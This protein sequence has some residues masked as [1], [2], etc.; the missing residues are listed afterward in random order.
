MPGPP[1]YRQRIYAKYASVIQHNQGSFGKV[2]RR[3]WGKAYDYYL[4]GWL[5]KPKDC[6][7][8]DLGC[9]DGRLLFFFKER[10]Y[11]RLYGVDLSPEQVSLAQQVVPHIHQGDI[12]DY[13]QAHKNSFELITGLDVIEH[14]NKDE[15]LN[16]LDLCFAALRSGGR[17]VLQTPNAESPWGVSHRY[18][19]FTH[20]T[21]FNPNALLC[22]LKICGF[23]QLEARE[24]G[25]VPWRYSFNSTIRYIIWQNIRLALMLWNI[26]EMGRPGS[27]VFTRMFLACAG[28][29]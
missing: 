10:G 24:Q 18:N 27:G 21:F 4:R 9:G 29:K 7:I 15:V 1:S 23:E 16:F 19:D 11:S 22:L 28:K 8:L 3:R 13:L 26:V 12:L 5:P 2:P 25:P 14:F 20:E 6:P 17:L